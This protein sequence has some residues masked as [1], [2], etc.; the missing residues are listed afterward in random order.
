MRKRSLFWRLFPTYIIAILVCAGAISIY[1]VES[2]RSFHR[3]NTQRDLQARA[4]FVNRLISDRT[5]WFQSGALEPFC[6]DLDA[7]TGTRVTVI[8]PSGQVVADSGADPATMENHSDRPEIRSALSGQT[9]FATRESPTMR[10]ETMYCAMPVIR[11]SRVIAVAR[12]AI[13]LSHIDKALNSVYWRIAISAAIAMCLAAVIGLLASS[14]IR[15]EVDEI[16]RGA[17]RFARGDFQY[18]LPASGVTEIDSLAE[19]LGVMARQLDERVRDISRRKNEQQAMLSSMTE[20]VI[21]VDL[22]E[23]IISLNNAAAQA[24]SIDRAQAE[25]RAVQEVVRNSDLERLVSEVLSGGLEMEKEIT[26]HGDSDRLLQ[27]RGAVLKDAM[28]LAI[29]ALVVLTDVTRLRRLETVRRDFVANVSHELK[30]PVTSIKGFVET[31]R[32][33]AIDEPANARRFLDII[34]RQVDRLNSIIDDLLA[35]SRIEQESDKAQIE[36]EESRICD[37]LQS[38]IN[39]CESRR[40]AKRVNISFVCDKDLLWR[41]NPALLEQAVVNLIDNAIKYSEPESPVSVEAARK[42]GRVA[43]SVRDS[44]CGIEKK[45]LSRLF[46]RFYRIDKARSR[47]LGGT[48]LG[49]AIV[50]HIAQAH[51]GSVE[52]ESTP[53]KGSTFTVFLPGE[54]RS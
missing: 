3:A 36:L 15:K 49:L 32:E 25:G 42:D 8:L 12:V 7:A 27:V 19:S 16:K 1:A 13:P 38:A 47:N 4:V 45:H 26:V 48:G 10:Q 5:T 40:A 35:L 28:G 17:E 2:I 14:R 52:V 51:G 11:D 54:R 30:T 43:I 24:L 9:G 39:A 41:V 29:G 53:G 21:A 46:E 33:G 22:D 50:K 20:G 44:G 18:R 23:K 34:V 31:L 37:V 6:K